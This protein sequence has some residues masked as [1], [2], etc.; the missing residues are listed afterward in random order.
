MPGADANAWAM[1]GA[2]TE[3]LAALLPLVRA[4]HA[5]EGIELEE[6]TRRRAVEGLLADRQL[7]GVWLTEDGSGAF[8][9]IAICYGY[10]IELGGRDAFV[11]ELFLRPSHRGRGIGRAVIGRVAAEAAA[12]GVLALHLEVSRDNER[13]KRLYG[14]AGFTSRERFHLMSLSLP[15]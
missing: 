5:F 6:E 4:Y 12:A 3:D 15:S 7:G 13:A 8:G 1:R 2:S 10:S 9:Y 14:A 11:D